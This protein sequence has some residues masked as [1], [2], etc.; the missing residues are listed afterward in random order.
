MSDSLSLPSLF[1]KMICLFICFCC[2]GQRSWLDRGTT[3]MKVRVC[4]INIPAGRPV[5]KMALRVLSMHC[6]VS[7]CYKEDDINLCI[8]CLMIVCVHVCM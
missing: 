7:Y 6:Y 3:G 8:I 5:G 2:Q 4:V 1:Q